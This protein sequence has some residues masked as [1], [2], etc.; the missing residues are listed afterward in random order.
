[1]TVGLLAYLAGDAIEVI[2]RDVGI[3]ALVV[4]AVVAVILYLVHRRRRG[5][6][7]G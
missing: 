5:S 1:V 3:G 4:V 2:V 6:V 7:V